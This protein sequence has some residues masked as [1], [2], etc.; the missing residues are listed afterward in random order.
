MLLPDGDDLRLNFPLAALADILRRFS[1]ESERLSEQLRP[2]Q[3]EAVRLLEPLSQHQTTYASR[4]FRAK[5]FKAR[6]GDFRKILAPLGD[7]RLMGPDLP[8][9]DDEFAAAVDIAVKKHRAAKENPDDPRSAPWRRLHHY[10]IGDAIVFSEYL[11]DMRRSRGRPKGK[12]RVVE[13]TALF[14]DMEALVAR[15]ETPTAAA[16]QVLIAD[17]KTA[18]LKHRADYL[19]K[20]FRRR[21]RAE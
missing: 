8:Q 12:G 14:V 16:R 10:P 17:G 1:S 11:P 18:G 3:I 7:V 6:L 5:Q 15:G 4:I 9:W 13:K 21:A 19:V 2:F 20:L